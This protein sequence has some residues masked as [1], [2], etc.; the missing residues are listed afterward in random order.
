[1]CVFD[2]IAPVFVITL[3]NTQTLTLINVAQYSSSQF[4][5]FLATVNG[6]LWTHIVDS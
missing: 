6:D 2:L 4:S 1:M 5:E 3:L